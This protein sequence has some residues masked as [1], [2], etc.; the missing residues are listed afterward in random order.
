M[1][2][3][4]Q[5][6]RNRQWR[7]FDVPSRDPPF[8]CLETY[9]E[10]SLS[11]RIV[12]FYRGPFW[13]VSWDRLR[14]R[15]QKTGE[16]KKKSEKSACCGSIGLNLGL[17]A[18]SLKWLQIRTVPKITIDCLIGPRWPKNRRK[19]RTRWR[20]LLRGIDIFPAVLFFAAGPTAPNDRTWIPGINHGNFHQLWSFMLNIHIVWKIVNT[21]NWRNTCGENRARENGLGRPRPDY[22]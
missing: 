3:N 4:L 5:E 16:I 18:S 12:R 15:M 20:P 11:S 9:R 2:K 14:R 22:Q 21:F 10:S 7:S 19:Q 1:V 6:V 13:S 8:P 17:A